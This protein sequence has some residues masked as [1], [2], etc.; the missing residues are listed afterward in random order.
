LKHWVQIAEFRI[1]LDRAIALQKD[2]ET[3]VAVEN[4]LHE[5]DVA[6]PDEK[7]ADKRYKLFTLLRER[8]RLVIA[9]DFCWEFSYVGKYRG[10]YGEL[11][12]STTGIAD[13]SRSKTPGY[14]FMAEK[15]G[16]GRH[17]PRSG[18]IPFR[19]LMVAL[20]A[21]R[22]DALRKALKG[23]PGCALWRFVSWED[24]VP[25]KILHA[26]IIYKCDPEEGQNEG[27]NGAKPEPLVR[28]VE[29]GGK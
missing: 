22:R 4:F 9:P 3:A 2:L 1:R 16:H 8:P 10:F 14:A 21:N 6:N 23:R 15:M 13:I 18:N 19:V 20:D 5:W 25:E 26:P 11:D 7:D 17:F 28:K 24:W 29:G 27:E 12:R